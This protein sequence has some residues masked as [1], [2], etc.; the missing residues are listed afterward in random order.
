MK[1][2]AELRRSAQTL[3]LSRPPIFDVL[4]DVDLERIWNGYG[5][6]RWSDTLRGFMTW[7]YRYYQE[8]A[9]IHDTRYDF[10]DG[11]KRGWHEADDEMAENLKIQLDAKYPEN[12]WW[13][14]PLRWWA[15][16]KIA[17]ANLALAAG[18]FEAYK[19]ACARPSI[20]HE[21]V[22]ETMDFRKGN[23]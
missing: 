15:S 14:R 2:A 7:F 11:T 23:R 22:N 21:K 6:D 9:I 20:L 1:T 10:S 13:L 4:T 8:S 18:G 12:K 17:A 5:P 19:A 16:K 3:G